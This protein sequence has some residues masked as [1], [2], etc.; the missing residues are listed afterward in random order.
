MTIELYLARR[1]LLDRRHGAWGWLISL[2]AIGSVMI[3]VAALIVTLA[4][5]TGFREDIREKM[6]G[7]HPHIFINGFDGSLNP[8]DEELVNTL[9][10]QKK[11]PGM[12][13]LRQRTNFNRAWEKHHRSHH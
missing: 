12:V 3:G 8:A 4:V 13:S 5:M 6:L 9:E 7:I 11:R 2:I 1:H 10:T